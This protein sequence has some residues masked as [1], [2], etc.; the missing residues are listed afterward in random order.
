VNIPAVEDASGFFRATIR[1]DL[2]RLLIQKFREDNTLRVVDDQN[3]DSRLVVTITGIVNNARR[4]VAGNELE[5]SRAVVLDVRV[6][7]DDNVK[8]KPLYKDQSFH[9]ESLYSIS[10]GTAGEERAFSVAL[11]QMTTEIL[12]RSVSQW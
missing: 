2:R 12:N 10:E 6:T 4:T 1:D 11:D 7:L 5:T 3:A 9:S 8:R